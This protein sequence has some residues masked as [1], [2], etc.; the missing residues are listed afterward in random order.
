M[1]EQGWTQ[2]CWGPW[3]QIHVRAGSFPSLFSYS[4]GAVACGQPPPEQK[5]TS[6]ELGG[7][8]AAAEGNPAHGPHISHRLL[9]YQRNWD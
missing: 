9:P 6:K 4:H 3:W 5:K 8:A 1:P 2:R 7:G